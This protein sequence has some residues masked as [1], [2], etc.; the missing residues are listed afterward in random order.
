MKSHLLPF[1]ILLL[2]GLNFS[3]ANAQTLDPIIANHIKAIG[4]KE[5]IKQIKPLLYK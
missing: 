1:F 5:K 3:G 2:C 4:G